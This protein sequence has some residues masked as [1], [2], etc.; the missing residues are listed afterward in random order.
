MALRHSEWQPSSSAWQPASSSWQSAAEPWQAGSSNWLAPSNAT[1]WSTSSWAAPTQQSRPSSSAA[2]LDPTL[3]AYYQAE[4]TIAHQL[5]LKWR[6]R[7]PR[8]PDGSNAVEVFRGQRW[9]ESSNRYANRGGKK[10]V[11]WEEYHRALRQ[12]FSTE[13]ADRRGLEAME[14]ARARDANVQ[15]SSHQAA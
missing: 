3:S 1:D 12:G 10:R 8:N 2:T 5:G 15:D 11:Y 14:L 9:R 4:R 13:V 7:G 6:E